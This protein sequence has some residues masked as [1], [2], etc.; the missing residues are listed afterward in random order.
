M[1]KKRSNGEGSWFKRTI[2]GTQYYAFKKKYENN[3]KFKTF[4][5]KTQQEVKDKVAE[6]EK[7]RKKPTTDSI[8][9]TVGELV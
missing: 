7:G 4:Y 1:A 2:N 8:S 5:G 6:Y 3:E 9:T